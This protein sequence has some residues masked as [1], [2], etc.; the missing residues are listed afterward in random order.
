MGSLERF[1]ILS[2]PELVEGRMMSGSWFDKLTMR[3]ERKLSNSA[4]SS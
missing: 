1:L 2:P 3:L 4:P